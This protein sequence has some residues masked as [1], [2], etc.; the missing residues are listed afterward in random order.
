MTSY[1]VHSVI[2]T[3]NHHTDLVKA[4]SKPGKKGG[5]CTKGEGEFKKE[6]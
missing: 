5:G 2:V 4:E 6:I 3:Q 1:F